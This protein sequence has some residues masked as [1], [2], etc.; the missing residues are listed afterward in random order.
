MNHT[1]VHVSDDPVIARLFA[2]Y[3]KSRMF[4]AYNLGDAQQFKSFRDALKN[5]TAEMKNKFSEQ[6]EIYA[7][8][9]YR[10]LTESE[11]QKPLFRL[12]SHGS[13]ILDA[14]EAVGVFDKETESYRGDPVL[15]YLFKSMYDS[16]LGLTDEQT[17]LAREAREILNQIN[18]NPHLLKIAM[19]GAYEMNKKINL[20]E[21]KTMEIRY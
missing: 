8:K 5:Y 12:F 4:H 10:K 1:Q 20:A 14:I 2:T 6:E 18:R 11:K 16:E 3:I 19:I 9:T 13:E 7:L 21:K 17:E 15:S